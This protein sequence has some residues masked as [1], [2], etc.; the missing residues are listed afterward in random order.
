MITKQN[1]GE[2][3]ECYSCKKECNKELVYSLCLAM[4]EK[5]NK[6]DPLVFSIPLDSGNYRASMVLFCVSCWEEMAGSVY[7]FDI[8]K[9]K[10]RNK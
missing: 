10:E 3:C 6:F 2:F 5:Q 9:L 7:S 4:Y 8:S 1:T